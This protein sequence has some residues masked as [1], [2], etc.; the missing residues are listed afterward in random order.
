MI[1]AYL[2]VS[3]A[4]GKPHASLDSL[5]LFARHTR[6]YLCSF[7]RDVRRIVAVIH[8]IHIRQ[9]ECTVGVSATLVFPRDRMTEE[10]GRM[11]IQEGCFLRAIAGLCLIGGVVAFSSAADVETPVQT[12]VGESCF[13][14]FFFARRFIFLF[15]FFFFSTRFLA[16]RGTRPSFLSDET[17]LRVSLFTCKIFRVWITDQQV[18]PST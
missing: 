16:S 6:V 15:F 11:R 18:K 1:R 5:T 8:S 17:T 10:C 2:F 12:T 13:F 7:R 14:F 4:L 3:C 9:C